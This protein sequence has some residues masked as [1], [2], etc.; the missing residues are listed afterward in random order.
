M[1]RQ[2]IIRF[3]QESGCGIGFGLGQIRDDAEWGL[4][5]KLTCSLSSL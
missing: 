2:G 4:E 5:F 1:N 3:W